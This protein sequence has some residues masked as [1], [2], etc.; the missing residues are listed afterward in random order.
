MEFAFP[1]RTE[2]L[3]KRS[4]EASGATVS[5]RVRTFLCLALAL[6]STGWASAQSE[7]RTE[8]FGSVG[9]SRYLLFSPDPGLNLG[10]G[11]GFRPF[12]GD[13]SPFLRMLGVEFEANATRRATSS[14]HATQGHF[15]GNV[16]FHAPLGR[17]E[18]YLVVGGG[19]SHEGQT[20]Q[21]GNAGV[22]V[23]VFLNP[24]ISVRP[25]FRIFIPE[26]LGQFARGSV[27]V[28]YHW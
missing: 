10:G 22:G 4:A 25:E 21:T 14:G 26:Y 1:D 8:V 16:L 5:Y 7:Y 2:I 28:G 11:V 27:A 12:S 17:I 9:V 19:V 3:N 23:K 18:P 24:R 15:T 6:C 13:R 20:H